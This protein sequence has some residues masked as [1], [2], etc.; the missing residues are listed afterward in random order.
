M[1]LSGV[2][3]M[4]A[5]DTGEAETG[6]HGGSGGMGVG[7]AHRA[8]W[9]AGW[10]WARELHRAWARELRLDSGAGWA[11]ARELRSDGRRVRLSG[12]QCL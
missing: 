6:C 7:A 10:A 5:A 12:Q 2:A 8:R 9:G 4:E 11:R 1:W 3:K